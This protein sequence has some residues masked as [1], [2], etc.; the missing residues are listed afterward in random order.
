MNSRMRILWLCSWYPHDADT[1]DGDFIER[2]A[3]AVATL[4]TVDVLHVVQKREILRTEEP[5]IVRKKEHNLSVTIV[6]VSEK[7]LFN[8]SAHTILFNLRYYRSLLQIIKEYI[9]KEGVPDLV[10]LQ[11]PVKM[12][13][14][15][16]WL[17]K[18]YGLPF[19][20]T[21]HA[22]RYHNEDW[23]TVSDASFLFRKLTHAVV[24]QTDALVTVS[25]F[26]GDAMNTHVQPKA[27]T[28]VPNVV[29]TTLFAYHPSSASSTFRFLH[30]SNLAPVKNPRLMLDAIQ[31]FFDNG[32]DAEFVFTGNLTN[33]WYLYAQSIG[34]PEHKV[35]F[36]GEV[37]YE[38]VA[39]EMK[40]AH[41]F[42][43]FSKSETFSCATAEALCSGLPVAAARV[44][45][46]PELLN[47][48]NAVFA[49]AANDADAF[50]RA[51][52]QLQQRYHTFNRSAIAAHATA[53]YNYDA[54]A[55]Q[56]DKVYTTVIEKKKK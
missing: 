49:D 20:V 45:A 50:A 42:F 54:V 8:E 40:Q 30:V 4:H 31:L 7:G 51:L 32:G 36:K 23:E 1:F 43:I 34:L 55:A 24:A 19:V 52:L 16:L 41:A 11:V 38:Q 22:N 2:Q 56:I 12:G 26:L 39:E 6:Y 3:R 29:N 48:S 9:Q 10:H 46:L 17:K 14:G 5:R 21:E 28:V 35:I 53:L 33:E 44:G 27:F 18:K 37:A 15:A 47:T 25:Q 13:A